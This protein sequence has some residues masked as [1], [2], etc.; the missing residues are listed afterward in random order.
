MED[1][2]KDLQKTPAGCNTGTRTQDIET[3]SDVL[4]DLSLK[5]KSC[6][7]KKLRRFVF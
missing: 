3:D 1:A 7:K 4:Q 2:S 5:S 6:F